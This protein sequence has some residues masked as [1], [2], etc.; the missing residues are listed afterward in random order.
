MQEF[1]V[2]D[3]D[4]RETDSLGTPGKLPSS[5]CLMLIARDPG[6]FD[7][8][9]M[10]WAPPSRGQR[11]SL[12][13]GPALPFLHPLEGNAV[14]CESTGPKSRTELVSGVAHD[15]GDGSSKEMGHHADHEPAS[16]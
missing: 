3:V 5:L 16:D 13:S 11:I 10:L 4:C 12:V 1:G 2:V 9:R 6:V 7:H 15:R 14:D 8:G